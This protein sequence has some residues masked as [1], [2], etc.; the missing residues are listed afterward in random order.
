MP[1]PREIV[2]TKVAANPVVMF[3]KSY[4]QYCT[5]AKA[6]L[7]ELGV[8][9]ELIELD[10]V[11]DGDAIQDALTEITGQRTVPNVFIGGKSV[12]GNSDIQALYKNDQLVPL[13][14]QH[15]AL[16]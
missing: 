1:S 11:D 10:Q 15:G 13:L 16:P 7:R 14:K 3:S 6:L 5:K 8:Q 4:C 2:E 9:F 12:G